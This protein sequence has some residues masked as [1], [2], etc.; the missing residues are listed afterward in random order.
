MIPYEELA[1][2]NARLLGIIKSLK[3]ENARLRALLPQSV[4]P[5]A[6]EEKSAAIPDVKVDRATIIADRIIL[7]R[8]LFRGR[9]DVFAKRW[10]SKS[11]QSGYKPVCLFEN[12]RGFC[13]KFAY[14]TANC[15]K[16]TE[17][18]NLSLSDEIIFRHLNL[19]AS[20]TDVIGLYPILDDNSVYFLCADFDDK[21]CKH[22]F[23]KDVLAYVL[24]C[25]EWN[26]PVHI[27][28]SRSGNGAHVWI[29][30]GE[31]IQA[32]KARKLGFAILNEAMCREGSMELVSYD[33]FFPNQ[34]FLPKGGLENLVALPLQGQARQKDNSVFVDR[35]FIAYKD[36][37]EYLSS[38]RKVSLE[39]VECVLSRHSSALE[40]S[41]T[42]ET[43]PWETPKPAKIS[44]EDFEKEITVTKANR[45]YV[46]LDGLSPKV[47]NHI[48]RLAAFHN[49]EYY[50]LLNARL[51]VYH[52]PSIISRYDSS[53]DY[54]SVPRGC[55]DALIDLFQSNFA[56]W[57]VKDETNPG[58]PIEVS[59][60]GVLR[61]EQ[62][63]AVQSLIQQNNGILHATT[64]FGKTVT[65]A[66]I[67]TRRKVNTLVLVHTNALLQQWKEQMGRFL[68]IIEAIPEEPI[69][70]GRKKDHSP[71]GLIGGTKDTRHGIVD[72]AIIQSCISGEEV[73]PFVR[74]YGMV[75]VDECHHIPAVNF[76]KV[77]D[78][79]NARY[80]YGLTA[81]PHREDGLDPITYMQCGPV[82]YK[83]DAKAQ[84]ARQSFGRVLI[85]RFTAFRVLEEKANANLY[86]GDLAADQ[87]R[88]ELIVKD[89]VAALNDGRTPLILTKLK[90]HI[91]I[92]EN[93]LT[94]HC[95]N[96]ICL[97]GTAPQK[98]K[99]L[100]M[101]R[102]KSILDKEPLVVIATGKYVGEGFDFPR[103][104]TLFLALP[105][106]YSNIVQQYTGRLHREY[107]GKK[108]VQVYDYIDIHVPGLAK[109]YSRRLKSYAPIGYTQQSK[110]VLDSNPQDIVFNK[111]NFLNALVLDI[112]AA[113]R[114]AVFSCKSLKYA[115]KALSQSLVDAALRGVE[116]AV[117]VKEPS[118]RDE[119][120]TSAGVNVILQ[121]N[122][123]ILAAVIDRSILWYGNINF[124]GANNPDDNVMRIDAPELAS[125][126][127]AYIKPSD[128]NS[129][130]QSCKQ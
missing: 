10:V 21:T 100:A 91:A 63:T 124:T 67:I 102:L 71:I 50:E 53:N 90:E 97:T 81:T 64:A 1:A 46:P 38:I 41:A 110:D 8:S 18:Q 75:I 129:R 57:S 121:E 5:Q 108:E 34:D 55:E 74:D 29:F 42:S 4:I 43:K 117:Y 52:V 119:Y 62:E 89:V 24:V 78:F 107:E 101:E 68:T 95:G 93:M 16:C 126:M 9:T 56:P 12:E 49:P 54:I 66:A 103:L 45:I 80:V 111:D 125:E 36:Q 30:F 77:L 106:S 127:I 51:P 105:V 84:I 73:K 59:F 115:K 92:L 70:R 112:N 82:R 19:K 6:S 79:A 15:R 61:P 113:K 3:E 40:L 7:F 20:E 98:E 32:S 72:I 65:A 17:R 26:I 14:G 99:R 87:A 58:R 83:S 118:K 130:V 104:D 123:T 13:T 44:F 116:C 114:L 47:V 11:G 120:F 88:N 96:I 2:E 69:K 94:S 31:A 86:N 60:N 23:K 85:P 128:I 37:W 48:K 28:R 39:N 35:D 33:R 109:M 27:E 122:L 76:E 22:G 25:D